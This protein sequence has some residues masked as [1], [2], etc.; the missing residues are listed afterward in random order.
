MARVWPELDSNVSLVTALRRHLETKHQYF[1]EWNVYPTAR[2]R[3]YTARTA[4]SIVGR[5]H[6]DA[7]LARGRGAV[8]LSHHF[9]MFRLNVTAL[10]EAGYPVCS[11]VLRGSDY[12]GQ[13]HDAVAEAIVR[14]KIVVDKS[15]GSSIYLRR[16]AVFGQMVAILRRNQVLGI[17]A[18]GMASGHFVD[19]AFLGGRIALPAGPAWLA[20]R[21]G[22][23]IVPMLSVLEGLAHHKIVIH[24]ALYCQGRSRQAVVDL[25]RA[26]ATIL[27]DYTRRYPWAWWSWRR[28]D[29]GRDPDGVRRYSVRELPDDKRAFYG[30]EPGAAPELALADG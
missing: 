27:D 12:A 17:A 18:D 16:G 14:R 1:V 19:V 20:L 11:I 26:Y 8:V 22:A 3:R 7:A 30:P 28:L 15:M 5:E 13:T 4:R 25:V 23:A 6:L 21:S 29:I 9:G 10:C 2:G 24:P